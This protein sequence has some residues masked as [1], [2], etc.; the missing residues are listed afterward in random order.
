MLACNFGKQH[1][2]ND[3]P[4]AMP[5]QYCPARIRR[6]KHFAKSIQK[7]MGNNTTYTERAALKPQEQRSY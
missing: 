6:H 3:Q 4:N 7:V 1:P 2:N 5:L